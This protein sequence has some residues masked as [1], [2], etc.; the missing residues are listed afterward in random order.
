VLVGQKDIAPAWSEQLRLHSEISYVALF[1]LAAFKNLK[2][3]P[4]QL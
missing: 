1:D 3:L 2:W 4:V